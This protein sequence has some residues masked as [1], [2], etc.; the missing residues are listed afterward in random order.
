MTNWQLSV[1]PMPILIVHLH[2]LAEKGSLKERREKEIL[3]EAL[4]SGEE[5]RKMLPSRIEKQGKAMLH[6]FWLSTRG[7]KNA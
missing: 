4:G 1:T 5:L 3:A 7:C 2:C 6:K